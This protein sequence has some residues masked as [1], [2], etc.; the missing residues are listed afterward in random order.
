MSTVAQCKQVL[1]N[2]ENAGTLSSAEAGELIQQV[3]TCYLAGNLPSPTN[4]TIPGTPAQQ[5]AEFLTAVFEIDAKLE[6]K[7]K[8]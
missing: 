8:T 4:P 6:P 1:T 7:H 3:S 2:V 5:K